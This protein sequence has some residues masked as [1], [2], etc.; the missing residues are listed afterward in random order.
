M[1]YET[2]E[3]A[4]VLYEELKQNELDIKRLDRFIDSGFD[5]TMFTSDA[6]SADYLEQT[7]TNTNGFR[8]FV[9]KYRTALFIKQQEL[10]R[11]ISEL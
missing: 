4:H 5:L 1:D 7:L 6:R 2:F 3:K 10:R 11:R 9:E 8:Y